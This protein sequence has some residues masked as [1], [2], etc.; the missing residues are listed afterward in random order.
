LRST[1]TPRPVNPVDPGTWAG[2]SLGAGMRGGLGEFAWEG[3]ARLEGARLE[4][5]VFSTDYLRGI[6]ESR[7]DRQYEWRRAAVEV[8]GGAGFAVTDLP[9]QALFLLGGRGTVPGY[10]FRAYGGDRA[11]HAMAR[12]GADLREPWV[13]VHGIAAAGWS[14]DGRA[15]GSA[16]AAWGAAPTPGVIPSLGAGFGLFYDLL[17]IDAVRGLGPGGLWEFVIEA[18]RD[19]WPW[20]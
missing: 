17:R 2:G 12:V 3:A 14:R 8:E 15:S 11:A 9:R 18:R 19:F 5:E 4:G 7:L 16:L 1:G 6:L 10:P 13:R 20:L